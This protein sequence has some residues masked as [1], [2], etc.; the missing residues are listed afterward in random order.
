MKIC[1]DV[2]CR[3]VTMSLRNSGWKWKL[4]DRHNIINVGI[5]YDLRTVNDTTAYRNY[6][7]KAAVSMTRNNFYKIHIFC[8]LS[9]F[10]KTHHREESTVN[11][12]DT[13]S[14]KLFLVLKKQNKT[15]FRLNHVYDNQSDLVKKGPIYSLH[16][17]SAK[18]CVVL[19]INR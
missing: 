15:I 10:S 18:D 4:N 6:V 2:C 16:L 17:W 12:T 1:S 9:S 8:M 3:S 14:E 7:L 5:N 11:I 13:L 19:L